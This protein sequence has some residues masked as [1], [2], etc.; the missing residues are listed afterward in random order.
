MGIGPNPQLY[1]LL[2]DLHVNSLYFLIR[3]IHRNKKL[4]LFYEIFFI[5]FIKFPFLNKNGTNELNIID[6][7]D[8]D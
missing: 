4:I 1:S 3:D 7:Y 5:Y 8:L 6:D 2:L